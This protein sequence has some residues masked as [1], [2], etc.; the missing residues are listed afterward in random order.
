MADNNPRTKKVKKRTVETKL[1]TFEEI[2][3]VEDPAKINS[4]PPQGNLLRGFDN[5]LWYKLIRRHTT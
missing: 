2:E 4:P 3:M 1:E 5:C